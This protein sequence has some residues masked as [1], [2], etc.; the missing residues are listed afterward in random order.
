MSRAPS[1]D[2]ALATSKNRIRRAR[3]R[4]IGGV[5]LTSEARSRHGS[6]EKQAKSRVRARRF[7]VCL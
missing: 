3:T 6:R 1:I 2:A 4:V 7:A 5:S